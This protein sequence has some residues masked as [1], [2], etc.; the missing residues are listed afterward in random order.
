[1]VAH[2]DLADLRAPVRP[3][4]FEPTAYQRSRFHLLVRTSPRAESL[5]R[6]V[7]REIAALAPG[8]P[9]QQVRTL[10]DV[11]AAACGPEHL[12]LTV[13]SGFSTFAVLL[14]ALGV[15]GSASYAVIRETRQIAIRM[16]LGE[17]P[18]QTRRR[19]LGRGAAV[20]S[21]GLAAGA[22]TF[23]LLAKVAAIWLPRAEPAHVLVYG[24][25]A[26]LLAV[27]GLLAC[28]IPA[29]RAARIDPI[30]ALRRP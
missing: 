11:V 26:T 28:W 1:V 22:S 17:E 18:P 15:F 16:A 29:E 13:L 6:S 10:E 25:T 24:G 14:A 30:R 5:A 23:A 7:R 27:T 2:L 4:Y 12:A 19:V 20:V 9:V 8:V 21:L 3:Q